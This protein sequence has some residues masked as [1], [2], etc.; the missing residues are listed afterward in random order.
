MPHHPGAIRMLLDSGGRSAQRRGLVYS[1]LG[2]A[3]AHMS[4][5]SIRTEPVFRTGR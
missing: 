1:S 3:G 2:P 5:M 4:V